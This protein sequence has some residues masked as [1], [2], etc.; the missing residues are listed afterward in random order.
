MG[1]AVQTLST[2][3]CIMTRTSFLDAGPSIRFV[4]GIY[5]CN[6][7]VYFWAFKREETRRALGALLKVATRLDTDDAD[8][9]IKVPEGQTVVTRDE[10]NRT[11]VCVKADHFYRRA[12]PVNTDE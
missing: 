1:L 3:D 9:D 2:L 10:R 11:V 8:A 4:S 12:W 6:W 5:S 7:G